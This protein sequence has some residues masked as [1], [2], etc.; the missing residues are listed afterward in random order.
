M[1]GGGTRRTMLLRAGSLSCLC[2]QMLRR[3][4]SFSIRS[5]SGPMDSSSFSIHRCVSF[6][7]D[8]AI[9]DHPTTHLVVIVPT[10]PLSALRDAYIVSMWA[11]SVS[12]PR[13]VRSSFVPSTGFSIAFI[14]ACCK[15]L[16]TQSLHAHRSNAPCA[17]F[18][19]QI[20]SI[21][22]QWLNNAS[23][24]SLVVVFNVPPPAS[25]VLLVSRRVVWRLG[26]TI[27]GSCPCGPVPRSALVPKRGTGRYRWCIRSVL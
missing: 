8:F 6:S 7:I 20:S 12:A 1:L 15:S 2:F 11:D 13:S 9:C 22:V 3:R 21:V 16:F 17:G 5:P 23:C 14:N 18:W 26:P 10:I 24:S 27:A 25:V 4:R 19:Q